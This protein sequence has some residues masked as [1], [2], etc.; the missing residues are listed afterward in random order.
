MADSNVN[1]WNDFAYAAKWHIHEVGCAAV[2]PLAPTLWFDLYS[3][4]SQA[5]E[6]G[7]LMDSLGHSINLRSTTFI[8]TAN[9]RTPSV[10]QPT[11]AAA[12]A[13]SMAASQQQ[14]QQQSVRRAAV[15]AAAV[16]SISSRSE[17]GFTA[18]PGTRGFSNGWGLE[19]AE[20][21]SDESATAA[22]AIAPANPAAAAAGSPG[23]VKASTAAAAA[24]ASASA[25]TA[26]AAAATQARDSIISEL[27]SRVDETVNFAALSPA[28]MHAIVQ[29]QLQQAAAVAREQGV[30]LHVEPD[31]AA[32]LAAAGCSAT[33]GARP[34]RQLV[35]RHVLVPLAASIVQQAGTSSDAGHQH[36]DGS[37]HPQQQASGVTRANSAADAAVAAALAGVGGAAS[38]GVWGVAVL[39]C[40]QRS[41]AA[42]RG[43]EHTLDLHFVPL[44]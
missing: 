40:V 36:G 7:R 25:P 30:L 38:A 17:A 13:A 33:A 6:D 11:A 1:S 26:A 42:G 37:D 16:R 19:G 12:A 43:A 14:Q 29:Q 8:F 27:A 39:R 5:V 4:L 34:L 23:S 9:T 21:D 18:V 44:S 31:A 28:A 20:L 15:A 2:L 32:W 35:R 24:A 22:A 10:T 41:A 3:A